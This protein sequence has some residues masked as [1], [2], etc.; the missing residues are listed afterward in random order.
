MSN[1]FYNSTNVP[2]P[3]SPGSS[4]SLRAEF[5]SIEDA[6]DKLPVTTG[7]AGKLVV[8]N[9]GATALEATSTAAA[10]VLTGGTINSTTIGA[11]TPS[12]GAFT[13]VSATVGITGNLTGNV[14]GNLAGNVTS[15]GTSTFANVSISGTLDM[16]A[17]SAATITGLATPSGSTDAATKGYVDTQISSLI[18]SA[19]GTLDTLDELA[20]ALG[21]DANFAAT[22]A[23]SIATKLALAGGTMSGVINMGAQKI[24]NLA[25]PTVSSDAVRLD[26]VTT[27]YGSTAAAAASAVAT[28]ADAVATAADRVQTGL[29]RTASA[30]SA[31]AAT[32]QAGIATTKAGE[33]NASAIAAAAAASTVNLTAPGPIGGTTPAAGSFTTLSATDALLVGTTTAFGGIKARVQT[34]GSKNYSTTFSTGTD[35]AQMVLLDVSG[36]STYPSAYSTLLFGAG[37]T[38]GGYST[39]TNVRTG[40][41]SSALTFGT[42]NGSSNPVER[43]RIDSAG[44]F[45]LGVVPSAWGASYK[46]FELP[47]IGIMSGLSGNSS[48][49]LFN[50]SYF[51][52]TSFIY[53]GN[54]AATRQE[55]AAGVCSWYTAPSG[56]AGNAISFTQAMT[57]DASSNLTVAGSITAAGQAVG[58]LGIPQVSQSAAYTLVLTDAGKHIL[59]PSADT[60]ARI[61]TIPANA[62]VAFPIGTAVTF[63]NQNAGG[64]ITIAITTDTMRL[65][66]AGTTGSRTLAANGVATAVKLTA[67]EWIISGTNLT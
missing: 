67:T 6:F 57:L 54:G 31:S 13:T 28:A 33:A 63:V 37:A 48:A 46:A 43:M 49:N 40:A 55:F 59:H 17:G 44:N 22:T 21:D 34:E 30:N 56:T 23:A 12:T 52:G 8:V 24:T 66:G 50:N 7:N 19:P 39:V 62:S 35:P 16:D 15:A 4:A 3:S 45:G 42:S 27:L 5:A 1:N 20:A 41:Q 2:N 65:A 53:S 51:N 26:Y 36:T 60:T 11:T 9:A 38:S 10:L 25:T 29:D 18:A 14:G 47:S 64:V 58:Y 32:T 61:F